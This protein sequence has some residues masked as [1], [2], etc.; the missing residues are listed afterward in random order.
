MGNSVSTVFPDVND[1]ERTA[2]KKC[3]VRFR[4]EQ[5]AIKRA[6]HIA[7]MKRCQQGRVIAVL[8]VLQPLPVCLQMII[9][10]STCLIPADRYLAAHVYEKFGRR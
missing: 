4:R 10:D 7:T 3:I 9:L 1:I 2:R 8:Q 5:A 6:H